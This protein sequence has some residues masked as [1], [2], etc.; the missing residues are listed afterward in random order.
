[1]VQ[2]FEEAGAGGFVAGL[3]EDLLKLVDDQ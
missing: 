3:G 2:A 1:V